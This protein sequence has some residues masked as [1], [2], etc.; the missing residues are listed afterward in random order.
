MRPSKLAET[1][2]EVENLGYMIVQTGNGW[3]AEFC[4]E[5][6]FKTDLKS[7]ELAITEAHAKLFGQFDA[8]FN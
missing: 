8:I 4:G 1:K 3:N 5:R 2:A 7:E 6:M